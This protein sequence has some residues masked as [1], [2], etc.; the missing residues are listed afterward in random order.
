MIAF[1][2]RDGWLRAR[3]TCTMLRGER[4]GK[5][6]GTEPGQWV[7]HRHRLRVAGG[8]WSARQHQRGEWRGK[9]HEA[10]LAEG[11]RLMWVDCG[12]RPR[13]LGARR[14][15]RHRHR[16]RDGAG[17]E[18]TS[19][20]LAMWLVD[21]I[22]LDCGLIAWGARRGAPRGRG[23][24]GTRRTTYA[25]AGRRQRLRQRLRLRH[26]I[27]NA[28]AI[29][30]PMRDAWRSAARRDATGGDTEAQMS[31]GN[32]IPHQHQRGARNNAADLISQSRGGRERE[33]CRW[34]MRRI[35]K[36]QGASGL[37]TRKRNAR[38]AFA[39]TFGLWFAYSHADSDSD[40]DVRMWMWM[41]MMW[42]W[43]L[44]A[45]RIVSRR[46]VERLRGLRRV[47]EM[48]GLQ[49]MRTEEE[50]AAARV[51][52]RWRRRRRI[53][54]AKSARL[55]CGGTRQCRRATRTEAGGA[56]IQTQARV[57]TQIEWVSEWVIE[58][59]RERERERQTGV[60]VRRQNAENRIELR[61]RETKLRT[62][63]RTERERGT[64][65]LSAHSL[66][67]WNVL[68]HRR[69]SPHLEVIILT[70]SS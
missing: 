29:A 68:F 40:V 9:E 31:A 3:Q 49:R 48:W 19:E 34:G 47:R 14:G 8:H 17:K 65:Q 10:S 5:R 59:G 61:R 20:R 52:R 24:R 13:P 37:L 56:L 38:I 45:A 22:G 7:R 36:S 32:H 35:H 62:A 63:S 51:Q 44:G 26:A 6:T 15:H 57:H 23:A 28:S 25:H 53:W 42:L 12:L 64:A 67:V 66:Q 27:A 21:W 39:F 11:L 16:H 69:Q 58:T 46:A 50:K 33:R 54:G 43:I 55:Q 1:S 4:T 41:W 18:G 30:R 60:E 70:N 2:E